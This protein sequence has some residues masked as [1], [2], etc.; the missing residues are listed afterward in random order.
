MISYLAPPQL[1]AE[2]ILV[3]KTLKFLAQSFTIDLLTAGEEPDFK[4]DPFLLEEMGAAVNVLRVPNP[5]PKS[6]VMRKLYRE[7]MG[8]VSMLDNPLWLRGAIKQIDELTGSYDVLY[9]RSQ[10]GASHVAALHAKKKFNRPW[11]AQFSDPWVHNPYH[12]YHGK[13]KDVLAAYEREVVQRAD[14]L[15]FPTVEMRDLYA[16]VYP[17][18]DVIGRSTV[19]PHHFDEALYQGEATG[20]R[21]K[22]T[23]SDIGDFYGIRSPEPLL[24]GLTLLNERRPELVARLDLQVVGNVEG[25]FHPLLEDAQ[26]RL[27]LS[28]RRVGQV[29]YRRSLE[30]MAET[31]LLLLI[32]APS[33]VNLFLSS[34]LIDYIGARR[35]I[36]GITSTKGTAGRLLSEWGWRVHHPDDVAGI[37]DA[38]EAYLGDLEAKQAQ[39]RALDVDRFRSEQV[40][41]ES[42]R[43]FEQLQMPESQ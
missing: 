20:D 38:L 11:I 12:P 34:K 26:K 35:P 17:D 15:I 28:V 25:K 29:P 13:R 32:D 14:H 40:V 9:S 31:D 16:D 43:L 21:E 7:V 39:A 8:R 23:M 41:A 24:K 3:A 18:L 22:V 1:N 33:D 36:L 5:K 27:G 6:R 4:Q 37:A 2:S 10:P 30:L 19:L 42:V